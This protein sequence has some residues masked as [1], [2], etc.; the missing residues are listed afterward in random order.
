ML[1]TF[2]SPIH[3]YLADVGDAGTVHVVVVAD[4]FGYADSSGLVLV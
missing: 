1:D 2:A 3:N 4:L